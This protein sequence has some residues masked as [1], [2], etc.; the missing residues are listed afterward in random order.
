MK[1]SFR[2]IKQRLHYQMDVEYEVCPVG[3]HNMHGKVERKIQQIKS[4]MNRRIQ[5]ERLSI[6]QWETLVAQISNSINDLPLALGNV[7][8]EIE[9]M[10]LIIPNRLRLGINNNRSPIYPLHITNNPVFFC[11]FS[12]SFGSNCVILYS[13][14]YSMFELFL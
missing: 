4:S 10:D 13:F 9:T 11:I 7:V 1:L 14:M 12:L 6:L 5:N 8:S 2:D 3:G